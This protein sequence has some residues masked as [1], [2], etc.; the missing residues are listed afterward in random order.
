M[1]VHPHLPKAPHDWRTLVFEVCIIVIGILIAIGLDEL[2]DRKHERQ[3]A[4]DAEEAIRGEIGYNLGR[5]RLRLDTR[6]CIDRRI[7]EMQ[8]ILDSAAREPNI[9]TPSWIG[10]PIY[11][12]FERNRWDV[13]SQAGRVALIDARRL[14]KYAVLYAVMEDIEG[15]MKVEQ[16]DWAKL[17]SLEH[18]HHLEEPALFELNATV[19]DAR[20]R[21]WRIVLL[22][23]RSVDL[24][25]ALS[26]TERIEPIRPIN[27]NPA[28]S[29]VC[30]PITTPRDAANRLS[31]FPFGEP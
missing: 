2:V 4:V 7:A 26:S 25:K 27:R 24:Q 1:A 18:L 3:E 6:P 11:S 14:Y 5:L 22:I 16:T 20:Y 29:A 13:E 31:V 10:R 28:S 19:Q 23:T 15:E 30:L 8:T 9:A 17:R 12:T 21:A